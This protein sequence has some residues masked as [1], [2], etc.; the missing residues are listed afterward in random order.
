MQARDEPAP[1]FTQSS[2]LNLASTRGRHANH[3]RHR[4]VVCRRPTASSATLTQT[5]AWL[6]ALRSRGAR[7]HAGRLPRS[8]PC[9]TYPEIRLTVAAVPGHGAH[10][11]GRS[12]PQALHIATEGPLGF[13]ARRY[14]VRAGHCTSRL[15]ITPSSRSTCARACRFRCARP[16]RRAALVPR[17]RGPLHGQHAIGARRNCARR[18]FANL[19]PGSVASTPSCSGRATSQ[20]LALPRPVAA[21][22]G[23]VAVE[24]NVEAFLAMPW[25][26]SKLVIGD[27][28]ERAAT[29][30]AIPR[31][32]LRRIS[33]RRGLGATSGRRG[34]HGVS[35][36]Y[37][38]VR[39]RE[40]RVHGLRRAG[41]R[42][43]GQRARS[44]S[45][46]TA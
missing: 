46:R 11:Y 12:R 25:P 8:V 20:F 34:R 2:L 13:A 3:D 15:P 39:A 14:C 23:R 42:L 24:K 19:A 29:A 21:Y 44:T 32:A 16:M 27:G 7:D 31:G 38:H 6:R 4:R 26:G 28:P 18:G 5:A 36:P 37:R 9:P 35:E 1:G 22:V 10:K 33:L 43:P 41:R 40:S 17:R 45:S 30:G